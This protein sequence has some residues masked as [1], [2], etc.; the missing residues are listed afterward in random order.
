M[1]TTSTFPDHAS[2]WNQSQYFYLNMDMS[3][4][5]ADL[6]EETETME[7][8]SAETASDCTASRCPLSMRASSP[9]RLSQMC[10]VPSM[11]PDATYLDEPIHARQVTP[12]SCSQMDRIAWRV[13]SQ[14]MSLRSMLPVATQLYLGEMPMHSTE[15][16]W[17]T[18]EPTTLP[19]FMLT[20]CTE[21]SWE[22][23]TI[24]W[25]SHVTAKHV[26]PWVW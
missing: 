21:L 14:M 3:K 5:R 12:S 11:H 6:S 15:L 24:D 13:R 16:V 20:M 4:T 8:P 26:S 10:T 7:L 22:P 17:P 23:L 9:E 1:M 19:E 2:Q 18:N 25:E